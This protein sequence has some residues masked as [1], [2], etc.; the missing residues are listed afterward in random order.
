MIL[1]QLASAQTGKLMLQQVMHYLQVTTYQSD[2][3]NQ[4]MMQI[5]LHYLP[6]SI[7]FKPLGCIW[8]VKLPDVRRLAPAN[9]C[10]TRKN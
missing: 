9:S 1:L 3:Y 5:M 10:Q 8:Q 2:L 7:I 4:N 6:Q